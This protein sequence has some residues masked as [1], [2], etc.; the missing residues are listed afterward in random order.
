MSNSTLYCTRSVTKGQKF[1]ASSSRDKTNRSLTR[2]VTKCQKNQAYKNSVN[3][4]SM[5]EEEITQVDEVL[6]DIPIYLK[7]L[8]VDIDFDHASSCWRD[9]KNNLGNGMFSYNEKFYVNRSI[10]SKFSGKKYTGKIK[11]YRKPYYLIKYEDGDIEEM[12][13][14]MMKKRLID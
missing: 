8:D 13:E 4:F 2:S 9:N 7:E 5:D 3:V 14:K 10:I 6:M 11:S 1:Q 12:G